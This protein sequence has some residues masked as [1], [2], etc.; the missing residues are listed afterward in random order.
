MQKK[1]FLLFSTLLLLLLSSY[2]PKDTGLPPDIKGYLRIQTM[3]C[4]P[5]YQQ[6]NDGQDGSDQVSYCLPAQGNCLI[7]S[8]Q[9]GDCLECTNEWFYSLTKTSKSDQTIVCGLDSRWHMFG[10]IIFGL[11]CIAVIY[12]W[13]YLTGVRKSNKEEHERAANEEPAQEPEWA[14]VEIRTDQ[15]RLIDGD[16]D[17]QRMVDGGVGY[18]VL[19]GPRPDSNP[20]SKDAQKEES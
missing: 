20:Q 11:V 6:V 18:N 10:L 14:D 15:G 4:P 19:A 8:H 17:Y 3:I 13:V 7:K 9:T 5:E 1:H 16:E 12:V 2:T